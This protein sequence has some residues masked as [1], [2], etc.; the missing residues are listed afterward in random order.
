MTAAAAAV[1]LEAPP[2]VVD[3]TVAAAFPLSLNVVVV[4][5]LL[6]FTTFA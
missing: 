4:V 2:V 5:A 6:G 1:N 3:V